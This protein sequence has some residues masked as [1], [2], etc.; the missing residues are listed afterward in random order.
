MI[1]R[2]SRIGPPARQ[3]PGIAEGL[4]LVAPSELDDKHRTAIQRA[5]FAAV[6][7]GASFGGPPEIDGMA[8]GL[9]PALWLLGRNGCKACETAGKATA[10]GP[11]CRHCVLTEVVPLAAEPTVPA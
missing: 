5:W 4:R 6:A 1:H 2:H 8:A 3:L 7:G 9:D 10:V 11:V